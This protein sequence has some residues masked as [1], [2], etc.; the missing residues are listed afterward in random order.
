[1]LNPDVDYWT[2]EILVLT[3]V[4]DSEKGKVNIVT[5]RRGKTLSVNLEEKCF[6]STEDL[7]H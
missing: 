1:M 2:S 3:H 5:R 7:K 4:K 6:T